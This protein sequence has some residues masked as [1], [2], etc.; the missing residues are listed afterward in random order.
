MDAIQHAFVFICSLHSLAMVV[1]RSGRAKFSKE[2]IGAVYDI[3]I[4]IESEVDKV[5][6]RWKM[7]PKKLVQCQKCDKILNLTSL[8]RHLKGVHGVKT[9]SVRKCLFLGT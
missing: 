4:R 7:R 3:V 8:S 1:T 9:L 5:K 2:K 6:A